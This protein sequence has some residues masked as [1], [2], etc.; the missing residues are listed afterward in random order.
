MDEDTAIECSDC[1]SVFQVYADEGGSWDL[2][3]PQYCPFCGSEVEVIQEDVDD[4]YFED[5]E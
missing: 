2:K 5:D 3:P 1:G 4:Y